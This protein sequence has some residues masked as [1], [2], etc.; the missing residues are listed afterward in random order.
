[1]HDRR[2]W[3]GAK[4]KKFSA[5][6]QRSASI[7]INSRPYNKRIWPDM[8][9]FFRIGIEHRE[10]I[11]G[12]GIDFAAPLVRGRCFHGDLT[13]TEPNAV[14][15]FSSFNPMP[16]AKLIA[17]GASLACGIGLNKS[18]LRPE[19][20]ETTARSVSS[21]SVVPAQISSRRWADPLSPG[22]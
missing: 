20:T 1:M 2:V 19:K 7:P 4:N 10:R 22:G 6:S 12:N 14:K 13:G 9:R 16:Q 5:D 17:A 8:P 18:V 21:F 15:R 3:E 11:D